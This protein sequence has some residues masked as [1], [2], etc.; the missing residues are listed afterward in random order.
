MLYISSD[1][2]GFKFKKQIGDYLRG[3]DLYFKDLGPTEFLIDDDY[4]DYVAKLIEVF[5]P[6]KDQAILIC[7]S[8]QG[9]CIAANR[10]KGV[11]A[12]LAWSIET[13]VTS[14]NDDNCNILCLGGVVENI[15]PVQDIVE[16]F[17]KTPFEAV[18]RRVR[19]IKE[20]EETN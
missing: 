9:M 7:G 17:L 13:A 20:L 11:R 12:A 1:H 14:R 3:N 4:S 8:G 2:A 6:E 19:R 16:A 5:D 18:E 10:Y 15:D